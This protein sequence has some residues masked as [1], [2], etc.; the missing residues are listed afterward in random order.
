[1]AIVNVNS[2]SGINSIT[3]QSTSLNFYTAAGNTLSIGASV[4][5]NITGNVT[6]N[7]TGNVNASG[8]STFSGG[9]LVGTGASVSSPASNT[10][11]LGTN[12]VERVR[13]TDIGRVG[14][15][16][17]IPAG[18]L[19]VRGSVY[20]D[21][22]AVNLTYLTKSFSPSHIASSRGAKIRIGLDDGSFC[23]VEVENTVGSN[24]SFNSQNVHLINH[25]GG[26]SG[27]TYSLTAR[28]DGNI[29]IGS[30]NPTQKLEVYGTSTSTVASVN[31]TGGLS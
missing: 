15:G 5:G 20:V 29:G 11:T 19:D 2:I 8:L 18:Q 22:N 26:V 3:A 30:T 4:S 27:D 28:Y 10:L 21:N 6:G 12:N 1:M 23:G 13:I 14:I 25:N 17:T 7:L 16:T 31:G 9:L 24:A